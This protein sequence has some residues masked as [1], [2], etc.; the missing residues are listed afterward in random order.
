[1]SDQHG[2]IPAGM[3]TVIIL[4][5]TICLF[6]L[7]P[8][9]LADIS[10]SSQASVHYYISGYVFVDGMP[11]DNVLIHS[12][13]EQGKNTTT[14]PDGAGRHG[15][16]VLSMVSSTDPAR[17]TAIYTDNE[18]SRATNFSTSAFIDRPNLD[19]GYGS[20]N[21]FIETSPAVA[22]P[23]IQPEGK[24]LDRVTG[25]FNNFI[26]Q[27]TNW[28]KIN[29]GVSPYNNAT[30]GAV[31]S[32]AVMFDA[33]EISYTDLALVDANDTSKEMYH[34]I[35]DTH[36]FYNFT[37]VRNTYNINSGD[38][39]R[40]YRLKADLYAS[41]GNV[42]TLLGEGVSAPFSLMPGQTAYATAVIF[43]NPSNITVLGPDSMGMNGND[44]V[45]YTA[46]VTDCLGRPVPDGYVVQFTLSNNNVGM[47]E[48]APN[49]S[50]TPSGLFVMAP[51]S[52][53]NARAEYGWVTRPG[54]NAINAAYEQDMKINSSA[55]VELR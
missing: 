8:L 51:T 5:F 19:T 2:K 53:G 25:V 38:Y 7:T 41:V 54:V 18:S 55:A 36:G 27:I 46:N 34:A 28:V 40:N 22:N 37:V 52:G 50:S 33:S 31:V 24:L 43:T 20:L 21:L 6:S 11:T 13:Y 45:T 32:R 4:V 3:M 12:D 49:G 39:D 26:S 44:H 48:L 29:S 17:V 35:S 9:A 10:A 47:G 23:T 15:Y 16:Y 42:K 1:M 30:S 14:G